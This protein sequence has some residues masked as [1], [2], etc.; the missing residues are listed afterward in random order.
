MYVTVEVTEVA[1]EDVIEPAGL[2]AVVEDQLVSAA[3]A[4]SAVVGE[5]AIEIVIDEE[6]LLAAPPT[7]RMRKD[8]SLGMS[9]SGSSTSTFNLKVFSQMD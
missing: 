9:V 2:I 8:D 7:K 4:A 1:G 6:T 3:E 5:E